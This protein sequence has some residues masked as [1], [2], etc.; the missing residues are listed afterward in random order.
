[1]PAPQEI[2]PINN[3]TTKENPSNAWNNGTG[4]DAISSGVKDLSMYKM[5]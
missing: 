3:M 5:K 4:N 1:M 2:L